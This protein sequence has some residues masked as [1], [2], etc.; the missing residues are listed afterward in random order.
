MWHP[1]F[2]FGESCYWSSSGVQK[3]SFYQQCWVSIV[4]KENGIGPRRLPWGTPKSRKCFT[5][6]V[7]SN[8]S[9]ISFHSFYPCSCVKRLCSTDTF[10]WS[11]TAG[12]T[13]ARRLPHLNCSSS[14][15]RLTCARWCA[16][17]GTSSLRDDC[18]LWARAPA[19]ASS[20]LTW[21]SAAPPATWRQPSASRPCFAARAGSTAGCSGL[22]SGPW[23]Y[24]RSMDSAGMWWRPTIR[25]YNHVDTGMLKLRPE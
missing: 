22:C 25:G 12:A 7:T 11:L 21:A 14:A 8:T 24:T 5:H 20:C 2:I 23:R 19:R 10:R 3:W 18:T 13:T 9:F 15:T 17:S 1:G 6:E 4:E 16:T